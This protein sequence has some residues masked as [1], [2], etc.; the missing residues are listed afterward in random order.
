MNV[1]FHCRT[2][3]ELQGLLQGL[4][5]DTPIG[6]AE[7]GDPHFCTLNGIYAARETVRI[8][9]HHGKDEMVG[10]VILQAALQPST[11]RSQRSRA[12]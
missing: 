3:A 11:F 12:S 10:A 4:P 1:P 6:F 5:A 8:H 9:S 7:P 2:V